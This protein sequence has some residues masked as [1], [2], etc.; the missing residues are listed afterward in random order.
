LGP[1]GTFT[2]EAAH[3]RFGAS[4]TFVESPSIPQVFEMVARHE[5]RWGVV[6]I[7]NS[8]EGGVTFTQDTLLETPVKL[9]GE[10]MV[11]IEQCLLT[12]ASDPGSLLRIYSHPQGLAQC[13]KWLAKSLPAAATLPTSSTAQAAHMVR[14]DPSAGAIASRLAA[15]L[16]GVAIAQ[17]G[18]QDR[19]PNVT[20]FVVLGMGDTEPT[21]HDKTSL[22]FSTPDQRGALVR[23][24]TLFDAAGINLCR[25]E[26]RPRGEQTWQYV[27][28]VDLEGHHK[29]PAVAAAL[30]RLEDE[31]DMV[32]V[33]GSYPRAT[34]PS[35]AVAPHAP[36]AQRPPKG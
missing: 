6:P 17:T 13:R 4:A 29:D 15:Q 8:I 18:I 32:T 28:F 1:F 36:A 5:A 26:S 30:R 11:D 20:R 27:F 24:L 19:K 31:S 22:V 25:I 3:Q 12:N 33:F 7:E 23:A 10:V 2:H 21:G 34:P 16:A 9:C 14:D 35:H